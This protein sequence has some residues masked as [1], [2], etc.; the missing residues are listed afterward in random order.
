LLEQ[1][2]ND[3]FGPEVLSRIGQI[4]PSH[5]PPAD[6]PDALLELEPL[7]LHTR[8]QPHQASLEVTA[9]A[10]RWLC[11]GYDPRFGARDLA[12]RVRHELAPALAC[13]LLDEP[14]ARRFSAEQVAGGI[15]VQA[16][17]DAYV[18]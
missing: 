3:R 2:R 4:L 8:L 7:T 5:R 15:Q 14:E 10:R 18:K 13:A 12:R 1:A 16:L 17:D 11:R 9:E 6:Q